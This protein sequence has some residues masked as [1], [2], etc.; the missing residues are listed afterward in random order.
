[1]L[2]FT[3]PA[4]AVALHWVWAMLWISWLAALMWFGLL[5]LFALPNALALTIAGWMRRA[6]GGAWGWILPACWLPFEWARSFGDLRMTADH[7]AHSMAK[8]PF[9]CQFADVVGPYG[10][11]AVVLACNGLVADMILRRGRGRWIAATA[12]IATVIVVLAYDLWAWRHWDRVEDTVRVAI[13]QPNIPIEEKNEEA[14]AVDQWRV[15]N[16]LTF[17]AADEGAELIVWPETVRPE[18]MY[19][20]LEAPETYR[21]PEISIVAE[22]LDVEMLIGSEYGRVRSREDWDFYNA[23]FAVHADGTLDAAWT[24][25]RYLV[26]F[27]EKVPFEKLLGKILTDRGGEWRWLSGGFRPGPPTVTLP[28]RFG[29]AGVLIC[30]EQLFADLPRELTLAGADFQVVLTNDAW[31]GRTMFQG[32]QRDVLRMRAIE[33]RMSFVRAANTG[34]SGFVD[35]R[36][37]YRVEGELFEEAVLVDDVALKRWGLTPYDRVGD[38]VAWLSLAVMLAGAAVGRRRDAARPRVWPA[39]SVGVADVDGRGPR[40]SG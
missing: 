28:F 21:M 36:G 22:S 8:Y 2:R 3:I 34:I 20:W 15:L 33:N 27:V 32:Y 35:P 17:Q 4:Y 7:V 6:T 26:P 1:M 40:P 14:L 16:R 10:V 25:K 38:V 30:F 5:L 13:V 23:A 29:D 11:G 31:W 18:P 37:R 24:A 19:H 12:L 39:P 9:L